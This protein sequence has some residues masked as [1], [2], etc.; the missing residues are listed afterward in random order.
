MKNY[1]DRRYD[2]INSISQYKMI[3]YSKKGI[4]LYKK[5]M[6]DSAQSH[7]ELSVD[8][9]H[10]VRKENLHINNKRW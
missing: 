10:S 9:K 2:K 1:V 4:I 5:S 7:I 3:N 6:N 8:N